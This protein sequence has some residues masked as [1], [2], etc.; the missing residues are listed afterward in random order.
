MQLTGKC[1]MPEVWQEKVGRGL[2]QA[3]GVGDSVCICLACLAPWIRT[4][5]Q[6]SLAQLAVFRISVSG[7]GLEGNLG[8]GNT[9]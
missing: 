2:G 5:D 6:K 9:G 4:P 8:L 3:W 1:C 7:T